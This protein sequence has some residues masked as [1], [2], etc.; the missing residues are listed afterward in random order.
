MSMADGIGDAARLQAEA[1]RQSPDDSTAVV[2]WYG[3]DI[4][5]SATAGAPVGPLGTLGNA[6][7]ALDDRNARAGGQLLAADIERFR[8]WAPSDARFVAMGFSMGSTV[9]SAA[10]AGGAE[11]DDL[12]MM[13]SPGASVGSIGRMPTQPTPFGPD[14]T[15]AEFGAQVIDVP[16]NV[17]D[18]SVSMSIP[19]PAG[20]LTGLFG[21]SLANEV[22]D[23]AGQHSQANYLTGP[24]LEAAASV[25]VGHY[26][27]VPVKAGR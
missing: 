21:S 15:S 1:Q 2:A 4:P 6:T 10:A 13:G 9:V 23:L 14:P 3:Y 20:L 26:G 17:P 5:L 16:S 24:S 7:A 25:L 11:I 12:V 18:V 19:G 8:Q 27:D 22:A